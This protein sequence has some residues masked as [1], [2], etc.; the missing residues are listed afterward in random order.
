MIE[1]TNPYTEKKFANIQETPREDIHNL[2]LE[3]QKAQ[4][5]WAQTPLSER[6]NILY[7]FQNLLST[8]EKECAETLTSE[9]GKPYIQA[10][11]EIRGTQDRV[12]WFLEHTPSSLFSSQAIKTPNMSESIDWE[13]LGVIANISAWNYPYFVGSNVF[14]P[15]LLC[16]NTVLY[17]PSEV[18]P[19][20]GKKIE[21]LFQKAGLPPHVFKTL[22]GGKEVGESLLQEDIQGVFF[23][24]SAKTGKKIAEKC[25]ARMIKTGF[26]LG[27]KDAAY[28]REDADLLFSAQEIRSGVFYNAGQSCCSVER[29]Y[30]HHSIE[31]KFLDL[32]LEELTQ[33][34]VGDPFD[35]S[36]T[37]GPL[38]QKE[39]ISFLDH[40]I[41][42]ALDKGA[43]I[44][45]QKSLPTHLKGWFFPPTVLGKVNHTMK[46]MQEESFGPVVGIESVQNDN[47][48]IKSMNNT[49]Y[50]LTSSVFSKDYEKTQ[51][52]LKA[53]NTGTVY[54]NCCDRISPYL[55]WSGRKNSGIGSTLSQ[56]GIY[57]FL[58]PKSFHLKSLSH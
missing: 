11:N 3:S 52:L 57:S 1:I 42:D 58:Q 19:L 32:F 51:H 44:L 34:K 20:T 33:L 31:T 30:L 18:T 46:I 5:K 29:I 10:L 38:A 6:K 24:G 27:G 14:I 36:T 48:A 23:T 8:H 50:G 55:P 47:E 45:Y 43:H 22:Q 17:K 2:F 21:E 40:Q 54:W 41:K 16:G 35:P 7:N 13:P 49:S 4:G 9:M 37:L 12:S 56:V 28:V 53:L 26:E 25:S 39:H 15:A